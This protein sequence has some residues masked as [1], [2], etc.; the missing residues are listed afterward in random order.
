MAVTKSR[1]DPWNL[2]GLS[3]DVKWTDSEMPVG[4][5]FHETDT[6]VDYMWSGTAWETYGAG[7]AVSLSATAEVTGTLTISSGSVTLAATAQV[8]GALT[9][10]GNVTI[11]SGNVTLAATAQVTG[12]LTIDGATTP[13]IYNVS[14][15]AG[16]TNYSAVLT[17]GITRFGISLQ[18]GAST[19]NFRIAF[20]TS[21]V[22]TGGTAIQVP[23][24]GEYFEDGLKLASDT[25]LYV[26]VSTAGQTAQIIAWK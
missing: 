26:G 5:K 18:T 9:I 6:D 16:N 19:A 14:I 17:A 2:Y 3:T 25:T 4:S 10:S 24:D 20:A 8:T 1:H 13:L 15:T 7:T 22:T 21:C 23:G 11:A 12:T